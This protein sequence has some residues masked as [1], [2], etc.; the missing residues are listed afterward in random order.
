[1]M[2]LKWFMLII[3]S[4]ASI[5][6]IQQVTGM[7]QASVWS[8]A[9]HTTTTQDNALIAFPENM[10]ANLYPNELEQVILAEV[11]NRMTSNVVFQP[12]TLY[13]NNGITITTD[14]GIFSTGIIQS[15]PIQVAVDRSIAFGEYPIHVIF[16]A[17]WIG[18][19]TNM[20]SVITVYYSATSTSPPPSCDNGNPNGNGNPNC[21]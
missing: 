11:N 19:R 16:E 7:S 17:E 12:R 5:L 2:K 6:L 3:L 20:N 9:A 1:M 13:N 15:L 10:T 4:F 14:G 8:N 18:G 21:N